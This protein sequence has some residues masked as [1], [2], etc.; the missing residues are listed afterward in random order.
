VSD[1]VESREVRLTITI[2]TLG[3]PSLYKTLHS[4]YL[5][6]VSSLDKVIVVGDGPQPEAVRIVGAFSDRLPIEYYETVERRVIGGHPQRNFSMEFSTGTH[7]MFIDDDD[8]YVPGAL[9][10]VRK[11]VSKH[12]GKVLI[13]RMRGMS[14]RIGYNV[15]WNTIELKGGNVGTPMFVV[16]NEKGKLGRWKEGPCGDF[17][18]IE[19]TV[20]KFGADNLVWIDEVIAEI[21]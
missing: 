21:Y 16:P 12:D 11:E 7:L 2:P 14:K 20:E 17:F 13:F 18:F 8:A 9:T 1:I 6:G 4:I 19:S 10:V 5:G 15:L 3:R